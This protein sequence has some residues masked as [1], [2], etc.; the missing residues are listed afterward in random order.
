MA[1]GVSVV[2]GVG[3]D[4]TMRDIATVLADTDVPLGI[5]PAGTGNQIAAVLGIPGSIDGAAAE[6]ATGLG[7][8]IDLGRVTVR[9]SDG[10]EQAS[11]FVIGCGAGL[12]AHL[13]A[14][15][16]SG[17]KRRLGKAAYLAQA[18][19]LGLS[20]RAVPTRISVDD[21]VHEVES[22]IAVVGNMG[23]LI[24][25]MIDL[26]T[27]IDP[28]DGLLDVIVVAAHG[29][30]HG[31]KGLVDQLWRTELGGHSG[32]ESM[33]LRGHRIDIE[34]ERPEPLEI[35]GDHVGEGS[36]SARVMP[37]ALDVIVPA[38]SG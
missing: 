13:M 33:R 20:I 19:R 27:P 24:P 34:P 16:P 29:P 22:S 11:T 21:D 7:R 14:T 6:L 30:L 31:L 36:L 32:S 18:V 17:L 26:R 12:D 23:Q 35:D 10:P 3:G 37:A 15:T 1:R 8:T 38:G 4:G 28:T 25:G 9:P 2:V 5:V